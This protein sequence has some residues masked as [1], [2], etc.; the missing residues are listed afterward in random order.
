MLGTSQASGA[1][2]RMTKLFPFTWILPGRRGAF[3]CPAR[4]VVTSKT[5]H[6]VLR[7]VA[8]TKPWYVSRLSQALVRISL[9]NFLLMSTMQ[10]DVL[11]SVSLAVRMVNGLS[12]LATGALTVLVSCAP[13]LGGS[14]ALFRALIQ[15]VDRVKGRTS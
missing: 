3:V 8:F 7:R 13:Q 9:R 1:F 15:S 11:L 12:C 6:T 14:M 4:T 5:V 10:G 2:N